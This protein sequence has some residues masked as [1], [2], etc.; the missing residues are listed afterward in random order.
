M[1]QS[2]PAFAV[3]IIVTTPARSPNGWTRGM[4]PPG[5][6]GV[7][8]PTSL[9]TLHHS[10]RATLSE[11][12]PSTA[13]TTGKPSTSS[14]MESETV[15]SY[16]RPNTDPPASSK[17]LENLISQLDSH[18]RTT[19]DP[20]DRT[21][22]DVIA[23]SQ[24]S[25]LSVHA[26]ERVRGIKKTKGMLDA[27]QIPI[28]QS[29]TYTFR[30]TH[31][32]IEY[33][34]GNYASF[35][36]GRYGNPTSRAVEEKLAA[37]EHTDDCIISASGMN[38]VTTMMLALVP[39]NG[40]IVTTTDCYRRT[41]QFV[42]TLLLKLGISCTVLD[43]ADL[44]GLREVMHSRKVSLYFSE[45]PTN[46]MLRVVD[47]PAI[48]AMCQ[49]HGA[50]SVFDTTFA[51]PVNICPMDHGADLVLHSATKYIGGHQDV[52]AGALAGKAELVD[53]VRKLH[54]IL[55]GVVDP[56]AAYLINRGLKTLALRVEAHN[57][58]A[59]AVSQYLIT[60]PKVACVNHPSLPSHPDHEVAKK[61]FAKGYGGMLSFEL[62]GDGNPWSRETFESVGR[63]I[64]NLKIAYIGPSL[65]G[66]ET[67]VEQVCIMGYFDKPLHERRRLGINNGL[68]RLS[69]G[70]ENTDDLI[71]DIEEALRHA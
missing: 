13:P 51:T 40:H 58:N 20:S 4:P 29:A 1:N 33:N 71:R 67:I 43:P 53:K 66:C 37:L 70:I 44:D 38:A 59:E 61:L 17:S 54:S 63:F 3:P 11:P 5:R 49:A 47:I 60:H 34:R 28:V 65:G 12:A 57:R 8:P 16:L 36:Y 2:V 23:E 9:N 26:G 21:R 7:Q 22:A 30:T 27:I 18:D 68:I 6:L 41:R 24:P 25:T 45:S 56:Q 32:C 35:E 14:N 46:P 19:S 31:D 50:I 48:S 15:E 55:G 69:C 64:D 42:A 62:K 39:Q 52:M 10:P